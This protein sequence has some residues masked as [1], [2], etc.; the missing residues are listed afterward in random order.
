MNRPNY[1][2][3][4]S[5]T[6]IAGQFPSEAYL[7]IYT[8]SKSTTPRAGQHVSGDHPFIGHQD[9]KQGVHWR[10]DRISHASISVLQENSPFC[11]KAFN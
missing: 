11:F 9:M 10:A 8:I 5:I 4:N 1:C 7:F 2:P 6:Q 3:V